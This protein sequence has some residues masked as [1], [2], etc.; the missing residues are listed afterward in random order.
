MLLLAG[1]SSPVL[2]ARPLSAQPVTRHLE[3][4]SLHTGEAWAAAYRRAGVLVGEALHG[5]QRVLRDHRTG[6]VHPM[7][8]RLYDL[9]ADLAEL[10]GTD[11]RFQIISGYRSPHS[12]AALASR[13]SGVATRSL[14][15]QGQAV[16]IRLPGVD[17]R[18]VAELARGLARGGV[19]Y[20][21][22][23]DFVHVDTGRVRSWNG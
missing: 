5:F 10:A 12:N 9:L 8:A 20:Y 19:G 13:S 4:V 2:A 23:S 7:D 17:T 21:R 22:S 1:A 6:D 3:L 16:D 18:R 15:M 14:H 11:A